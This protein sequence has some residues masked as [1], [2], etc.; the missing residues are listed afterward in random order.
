MT[1]LWNA[2]KEDPTM[3]RVV[4]TAAARG[5][6]KWLQILVNRYPESINC[7][8]AESLEL[9][10]SGRVEWLSPLEQDDYAEYRDQ[11]F[12]DRLGV[13][14]GS[15]PL[16]SFW[17]RQGPQWDGLARTDAGHLILVEAKAH[18][19]EMVSTP[20][21]AAG[22]SLALIQESLDETK[23]FLRSH[24]KVDWSTCF[25]QYTNRLAHLYFLRERARLPA[26]LLFVYFLNDSDVGGPATQSEWEGAIELLEVFL[27][28]Q[29]HRLSDHILRTFIDVRE[30]P[31]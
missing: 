8:L 29:R 31:S 27:G 17:P 14:A 18:V 25:Y 2:S 4:Q 30:L 12:L 20:T 28:V 15:V 1:M 5:S 26:Y 16:K 10:D 9:G 22:K 13:A 19:S 21:G 11:A 3:S 24:A 7:V 23:R 6:Q